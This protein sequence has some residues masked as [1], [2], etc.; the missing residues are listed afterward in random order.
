MTN[1]TE[2]KSQR[3]FVVSW[4][5]WLLAAGML[6]V[7]LL[8]LNPWISPNNLHQVADAGGWNWQAK[9]FGPVIFLITYPFHWLPP[10]L[11]PLAMNLLSAVFAA[12]TLGMLARSVALLPHDRTHEQRQREQS[13]A[14]L[15]TLRTAWL[16]PVL[17]VL[18]CGLQMSFWENAIEIT[19]LSGEMLDLLIFAYCIRCLLEYRVDRRESWLV[20]FA[21]VYG[22]GMANNWAMIGFF[23]AFLAA[24]IWIKGVGFF[25]LRFMLR[26][27]ALGLAGLTLILL[28]PLVASISHSAT[29]G[30]VLRSVLSTSKFVL[31]NYIPKDV[32]V[33]LALT[34]L[35][36][37]AVI[38]IKWSSFF[39]DTSPLGII[40]A[41]TVFHIVHALLLLACIWVALD[42]PFSPRL[43]GQMV[44][45]L[46]FLTFYYLG[47]LSVGY[48]AGYFLLVFGKKLVK[49]RKPTHIAMRLLD[50]G[51]SA[52]IWILLFTVPV[53]LVYKNLPNISKNH[54]ADFAKYYTLVEQH[55]PAQGGVVLSD[56]AN[57]LLLLEAHLNK[58]GRQRDY[59]LIDTT[60]MPQDARYIRFLDKK[61]PQYKLR[62]LV[63]LL[64]PQLDPMGLIQLLRDLSKEHGIYYLHSTVGYYLEEFYQQPMG[65]IYQLKSYEVGGSLLRPPLQNREIEENQ[66][67]WKKID[68]EV[69]PPLIE[70]VQKSSEPLKPSL[71]QTIMENL[72]LVKE[73]DRQAMLLGRYYSRAINYWGVELQKAG[74]AE[75]ATQY[76]DRAAQLN[77]DNVSAQI[78]QQ[79]NKDFLAGKKTAIAP[80][81]RIEDK[82]G[83]HRNWVEVIEE[84]GPF[85]E[86]NFCMELGATLASGNWPLYRQAIQQFERVRALAPDNLDASFWLA[87]LYFQTRSYSNTLVASERIL[88][89]M[90]NQPSALYFKSLSLIQM[91]EYGQAI[92]TLTYLVN[93]QTNNY[94][95][96]LN[97]G[98]A[99][100][101]LGNL[102]AAKSDYEAVAKVSPQAYQAFYGLAEIAERNKNTPDAV[103]N[104]KLYLTNAPPNTEEAKLVHAR[105]KNLGTV[106]Q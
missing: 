32:F 61:Y 56:D 8:T 45:N 94:E 76:F 62:N 10:R 14:S 1:E 105:L 79:F 46:P 44:Y 49:T 15:L 30:Q 31:F 59:L 66:V 68:G 99:N 21:L 93:L 19:G 51:A 86:P 67:F 39:G 98:I 64:N 50:F 22:V 55:L 77:P 78:N 58:I 81:K 75:K 28:L 2:T 26:T 65:L 96:R 71:P 95:A 101:Q 80:P 85:D 11:L 16:P 38:G 70:A 33:L 36:P 82:F 103:K 4:L 69:L 17:A 27:L 43:K 100:L 84:D 7:Y 74:L 6:G 12:I 88:T 23:P 73:Q 90:T 13:A 57:R 35:L 104:Y 9:V 60:L 37:V 63:N 53:L 92:P 41:T 24:L 25:N 102:E 106:K 83:K 5:P 87:P 52:A 89:R 54:S 47:A 29:F 3:N 20:R 40:L 18:V 72:H 48:F 42:P 34:S 97:R 91:H